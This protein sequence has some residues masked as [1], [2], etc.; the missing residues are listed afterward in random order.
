M[1]DYC[2]FT[3]VVLS[4]P[5]MEGVDLD[6]DLSIKHADSNPFDGARYQFVLYADNML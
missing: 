3:Q 6:Y 2:R 1:S 5:P 4:L